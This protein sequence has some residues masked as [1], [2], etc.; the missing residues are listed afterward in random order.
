MLQSL[1]CTCFDELAAQLALLHSSETESIQD[2]DAPYSIMMDEGCSV[3]SSVL[4]GFFS[5]T[6]STPV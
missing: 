5:P 6:C 3:Y 1:K 2:M 4:E